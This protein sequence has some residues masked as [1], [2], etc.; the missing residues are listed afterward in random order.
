MP[1]NSSGTFSL[2]AG[3]PVVTGATIDATVFNTLTADLASEITDSLDR[4]GKGAMLQPLQLTDGDDTH[5]S[6]AFANDSTLGIWNSG[7]DLCIT[8]GG[9]LATFSQGGTTLQGPLSVS[10]NVI[11]PTGLAYASN[12]SDGIPAAGWYT[13]GI[14]EVVLEGIAHAAAGAGNNIATLPLA[15]RPKKNCTFQCTVTNLSFD[16]TATNYAITIGVSTAGAVTIARSVLAIAGG[17]GNLHS[18]PITDGQYVLDGIKFRV[19]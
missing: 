18:S 3:Q 19:V 7:G 2:P 14:G 6:L 11:A 17:V 5:P 12:W 15:A 4:S 9:T 13:N 16:S 10:P 1:R 8:Q